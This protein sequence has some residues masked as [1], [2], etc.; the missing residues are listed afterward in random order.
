[1]DAALVTKW[2]GEVAFVKRM[3]DNAKTIEEYHS[4]AQ[5]ASQV[6]I[7]VSKQVSGNRGDGGRGAPGADAGPA[8]VLTIK[9]LPCTPATDEW[10]WARAKRW[11]TAECG[12]RVMRVEK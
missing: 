10:G 8:I 4:A 2:Q 9:G 3:L 6:A 12:L 11:L 7:K 5:A 1:M